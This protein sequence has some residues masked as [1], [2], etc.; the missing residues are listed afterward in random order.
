MRIHGKV[1]KNEFAE[2]EE[3]YR[4]YA[5]NAKERDRKDKEYRKERDF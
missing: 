4:G 2:W 1:D 5:T 3:V